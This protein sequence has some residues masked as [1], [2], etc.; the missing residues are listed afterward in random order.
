M[1]EN[2]SF[3]QVAVMGAFVVVLALFAL[4]G[5]GGESSKN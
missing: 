4:W 2:S 3:F 1:N 5:E